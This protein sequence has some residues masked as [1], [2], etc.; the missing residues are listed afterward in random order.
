MNENELLALLTGQLA[1]AI[2]VC[3]VSSRVATAIGAQTTAVWLSPET[4]N[5][6]EAKR[7]GDEH[8]LYLK[9]PVV[10]EKGYVRIEPPYHAIFI[11]HER[12]EKL[13]SFKAVVKATQDGQRLYLQSIHRVERSD[14]RAIYR[15]TEKLSEW[16]KRR[17]VGPPKN[18]T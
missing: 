17:E 1:R 12:R 7:S 4:T 5:K 2:Y 11:Y 6:Q 8:A 16:E 18:P 3:R 9:A 13:R 10:I 14:V 15:K